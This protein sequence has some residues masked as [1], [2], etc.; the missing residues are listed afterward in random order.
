[1]RDRKTASER[2]ARDRPQD[3]ELPQTRA[4]A[5]A[6]IEAV[7]ALMRALDE[8]R[9]SADMTKAA[10]AERAKI[11]EASVR[12]LFTSQSANPAVKTLNRLARPLGLRL[13]LVKRD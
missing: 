2:N 7:D 13:T 5:L 1:M 4:E 3:P 9:K 12:K 11:P 8:A 6:E 10:L